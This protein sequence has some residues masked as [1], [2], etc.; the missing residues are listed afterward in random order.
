VSRKK[1]AKRRGSSQEDIAIQS[2][3]VAVF[4]AKALLKKRVNSCFLTAFNP[5]SLSK[6]STH[7]A[8]HQRFFCSY[9]EQHGDYVLYFFKF[10]REN[11]IL[12]FI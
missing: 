10:D 12:L 2:N 3:H 8:L 5:L 9:Y 1:I 11:R 6:I 4:F 7:E